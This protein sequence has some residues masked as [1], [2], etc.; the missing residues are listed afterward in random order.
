M[1]FRMQS[2][3]FVTV[4]LF[5]GS[6]VLADEASPPSISELD[7]LLGTWEI[8]FEI[9]DTHNPDRGVIIIEKGT[10]TCE[11]DLL[12]RG[13][14]IFITCV[15]RVTATEDSPIAAGRTREFREAIRYN[16]FLGAFERIGQFSNWPAHAEEIV[17]YHPDTHSLELRG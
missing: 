13:E 9:H 3:F 6:T 17:F 11:K 7:F 4:G 1:K 2:I 15:G 10:Q 8:S 5:L 16:R 14:P 12:Y